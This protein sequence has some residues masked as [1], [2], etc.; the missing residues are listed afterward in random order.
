MPSLPVRPRPELSVPPVPK[1]EPAA[2]CEP[3]APCGP[4]G[5]ADAV[6]VVLVVVVSVPPVDVP[7][8]AG[9]V[10]RRA[11]VAVVPEPESKPV[12][13]EPSLEQAASAMQ[14]TPAISFE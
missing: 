12:D 9:A 6:C 5:P 14:Q 2:P 11:V 13:K 4:A 7:V 8:S 3:V 1:K 10:A